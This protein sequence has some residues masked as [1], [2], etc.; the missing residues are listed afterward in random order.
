MPHRQSAKKRLRQTGKRTL[1][2]KQVKSRLRTEQN[3]FDH[4]LERGD[5]QE[6]ERQISLLT[7]LYHQAANRKVVEKNR[8]ARKQAQFQRRLNEARTVAG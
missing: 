2:N 5:L 8:A 4:M 6:A 1:R 3:K 7:K